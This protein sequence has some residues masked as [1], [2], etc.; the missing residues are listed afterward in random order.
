MGKYDFT[1]EFPEDFTDRI[2]QV[3]QQL[4]YEN[5]VQPFLN[6]KY[7]YKDMGFARYLGLKGDVWNKHG[8]DFEI[9]GNNSDIEILKSSVSGG[10][11]KAIGIALNS[12]ESGFLL[13][14]VI[15]IVS[16]KSEAST[17]MPSSNE[18][19]LK[20]EIISANKIR[21]DL[22]EVGERACLNVSY[23]STTNENCIND[24][25]RDMLS[26]KGYGQVKDQTRHGISAEENEAGQVDMLLTKGEKEIALIEGMKLDC[27]STA[28]I[29]KH[30]QK[31][32]CNYNPLGTPT[33][34]VAY[35]S[36][37]NFEDFWKKYYAYLKQFNF[38]LPVQTSLEE[39]AMSSATTR[40]ASLTLAKDGYVFPVYFLA[41]KIS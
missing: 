34:I 2:A 19:R 12:N 27:V 1:Y 30:I 38:P 7:H 18:E 10:L 23:N 33:F 21:D 6:C 15:F 20:S 39:F 14:K 24:Y 25:F 37:L 22:I 17:K 16:R 35:V 29:N 40:V 41:F 8:L 3:L 5:L 31:A 32:I 4:G 26:E 9:D 13:N 36:V 11:E 28:Y